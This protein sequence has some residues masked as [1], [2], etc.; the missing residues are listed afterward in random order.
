[1]NEEYQKMLAKAFKEIK[2]KDELLMT[3]NSIAD[4]HK[5]IKNYMKMQ[6]ILKTSE[7]L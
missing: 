4:F 2:D 6:R 5:V 1:M 7:T 3:M